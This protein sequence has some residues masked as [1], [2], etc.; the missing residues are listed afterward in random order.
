MIL[1]SAIPR[2]VAPAVALVCAAPALHGCIA[3]A[4]LP[5][6][7]G[8][9]VAGTQIMDE[10]GNAASDSAA[11]AERSAIDISDDAPTAV[12]TPT[13]ATSN[14]ATAT[15]M[16]GGVPVAGNTPV[17]I[18]AAPITDG[19]PP[20][21][22]FGNASTTAARSAGGYA[23]F[24]NFVL[25]RTKPSRLGAKRRAVLLSQPSSL[26]DDRLDCGLAQRAVLLDLDPAGDIFDPATPPVADPSLAAALAQFR[27]RDVDIIWISGASAAE[28][29][30]IRR[31]LKETGLDAAGQD[32]LLLMRYAEDRKQTRRRAI[33]ADRCLIAIAG[34]EREDFD[35]LYAYLRNPQDAAALEGIIGQGWF[36]T[37][38]PLAGDTAT[39]DAP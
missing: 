5:V 7:A 26:R 6:L 3:V 12:A 32:Q 34:D 9:T 23:D 24:T 28:A 4:A 20:P 25:D 15:R 35:E 8:G 17:R 31:A 33:G 22:T 36:L 11:R 39:S 37:P 19:P 16:S 13:I 14:T 30:S 1:R 38:T 21:L 18:A 2:K 10:N 29:G 27:E